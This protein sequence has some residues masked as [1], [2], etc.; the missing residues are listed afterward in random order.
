MELMCLK[1]L[2]RRKDL[3]DRLSRRNFDELQKA[4][5]IQGVGSEALRLIRRGF[6]A[7]SASISVEAN[8]WLMNTMA[9]ACIEPGVEAV[10]SFEDCSLTQFREAGRRGKLRIYDMPIGYFEEWRNVERVLNLKY[11]DW[12]PGGSSTCDGDVKQFQKK[13]EM[14]LADL[15]I[16]PS[17]F[18]SDTIKKYMPAK[19]IEVAP[20]GVNSTFWKITE[21][22]AKEARKMRFICAGQMSL[23]KGTP[24]LLEAWTRAAIPNAELILVGL[25]N[26][27]PNQLR[28]LPSH[29]KYVPQTSREQL[30]EYYRESDVFVL[31]TNFEGLALVTLEAMACELPVITTRASGAGDIVSSPSPSGIVIPEDEIDA[32]I[33]ALRWCDGNRDALRVM[34]AA[35]RKKAEHYCWYNYRSRF[36][37]A[38]KNHIEIK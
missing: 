27:A 25:W 13:E 23:R 28:N 38:L 15:V 37:E 36:R 16:C 34:G 22:V 33:E 17:S 2:T 9:K 18:V 26:L 24:L 12:H 35:A 31:P 32:L 30:R 29:V 3:V 8:E 20:Y 1:L 14:E 4:R 10:H 5:M 11:S 6:G 7:D 19:I 21:E